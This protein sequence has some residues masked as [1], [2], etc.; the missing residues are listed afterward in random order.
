MQSRHDGE[1]KYYV[2]ALN[3]TKVF[4][5]QG[6]SLVVQ[7]NEEEL[8]EVFSNL[9]AAFPADLTPVRPR[10]QPNKEGYR[11]MAFIREWDV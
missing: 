11:V 1:K 6:A 8:G 7:L 10:A 2:P 3:K 4:I 5:R 9:G